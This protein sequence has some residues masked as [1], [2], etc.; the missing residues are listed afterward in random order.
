MENAGMIVD[1]RIVWS[2]RYMDI[3]LVSLAPQAG[4]EIRTREMAVRKHRV[5]CILP[6]TA[7][8]QLVLIC[9][10]RTYF[11]PDGRAEQRPTW[12]FPAGKAGDVVP[13]SLEDAARRELR[14]E[15]GYVADR[16]VF[17]FRESVSAG[18]LGEE[19]YCYFAPDVRL[20]TKEQSE[21]SDHIRV[22]LVDILRIRQFIKK[23]TEKGIEIDSGI[24]SMLFAFF[25]EQED[26]TDAIRI[27]HYQD[28]SLEL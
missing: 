7:D 27:R 9:Q 26:Y 22:A 23:E 10:D 2:G 20:A 12:E 6:L 11:C 18:I 8:G 19:R 3:R 16:L 14:E 21:E 13:E 25:H 4:G 5:V 28:G 17:L 24:R 1:D 15:T